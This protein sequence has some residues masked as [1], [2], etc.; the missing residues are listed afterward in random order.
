[1]VVKYLAAATITNILSL[2]CVPPQRVTIV[3]KTVTDEQEE[4][5]LR[6]ERVAPPTA[7]AAVTAVPGAAAPATVA[8]TK[9]PTAGAAAAARVPDI[10]DIAGVADVPEVTPSAPEVNQGLK[11][12]SVLVQAEETVKANRSIGVAIFQSPLSNRIIFETL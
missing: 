3:S 5:L 9:Q 10:A 8:A 11:L 1:M 6:I 12:C 7:V 2:L 4:K